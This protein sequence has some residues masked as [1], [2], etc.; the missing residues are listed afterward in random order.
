MHGLREVHGG[1]GS[2]VFE[3]D[4]LGVDLHSHRDIKAAAASVL[5]PTWQRCGV[6]LMRNALAH[7]GRTQRRMVSAVRFRASLWTFV[8]RSA[9]WP[10]PQPEETF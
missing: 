10:T 1:Y 8:S 2:T 5:K 9:E 6:H 4:P 7:V 3:V